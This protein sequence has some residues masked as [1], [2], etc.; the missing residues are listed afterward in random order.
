M[1]GWRTTTVPNAANA[2]DEFHERL[3][4]QELQN[5]AHFDA[6]RGRYHFDC[7]VIHFAKVGFDQRHLAQ[8]G[9]CRLLARTDA[10][11]FLGF[12]CGS[13]ILDRAVQAHGVAAAAFGLVFQPYVLLVIFAS[14]A[15]GLFV[16]SIPGLTATMA[17]ALPPE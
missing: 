3:F 17:T 2:G 8:L 10:K 13:D 9:D 1:R 12:E 6:E 4:R 14:A 15:F 16:G 5:L 11:V 7:G